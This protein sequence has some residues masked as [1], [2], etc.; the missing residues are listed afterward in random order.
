MIKIRFL[1]VLRSKV[2]KASTERTGHLGIIDL[3]STALIS[4]YARERGERSDTYIPDH[5]APTKIH[6]QF[7]DP[8]VSKT[9]DVQVGV[10]SLVLVTI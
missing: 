8:K 6:G 9:K 1:K 7:K 10:R 5:I 3:I 2:G 4:E